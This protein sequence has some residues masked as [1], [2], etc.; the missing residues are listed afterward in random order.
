MQDIIEGLDQVA[1]RRLNADG[2]EG[3][4]R[5][6]GG[7]SQEIW[8]FETVSKRGRERF[9][10]RRAPGGDRVSDS[11]V[12]PEVEAQLIRAAARAEVPVPG[13]P[14]VLTEEDGLGRGYVMTCVEGE[15]LGGRI[16]RNPEF[17]EARTFMA[18]QC[19]EIFARI[20]TIDPA[21]F[22]TLRRA[23]PKEQV[24]SLKDT[25]LLSNWP[26]PVFDLA[27]VWLEDNC[28]DGLAPKLIHGDFRTG[29]LMIGPDGVRAVLDWEIAHVADPMADLGWLCTACWRFGELEKPCGGFGTREDLWAGYEAVSGTKVDRLQAKFWE[30]YGSLRW[31][32]MCC[33]MKESF[34][35]VDPSVERAVIARRSSEN[36]IDLLRLLAA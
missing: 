14:W 29:N 9:I 4:T 22:P 25:Y 8:R 3:V 36:E 26:R 5:L 27:F 10:L 7:A 34:R 6:S 13:V 28:P 11:A 24:Q 32:V 20:H 33:N 21:E 19:G 15:T 12:G 16:V 17:A 35:T 1:R 23:N 2:V 31:G 30:V 18:R